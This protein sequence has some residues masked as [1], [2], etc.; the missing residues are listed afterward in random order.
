MAPGVKTKKNSEAAPALSAREIGSLEL[1]TV[2]G[3]VKGRD[4]TKAL[5]HEHMFVDFHATSD[6]DY[7]NVN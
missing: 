5:A 2:T 4:V 7:M 3:I 6:A 1:Q